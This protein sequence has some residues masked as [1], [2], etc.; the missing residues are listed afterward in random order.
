MGDMAD[1][2]IDGVTPMARRAAG[3]WPTPENVVASLA[4][5]FATAADQEQDTERR[6]IL[7]SI[8]SFLAGTGKDLAAEV[9]AKVVA[10]Q[11]GLG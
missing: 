7:R 10:R 4:V 8:A 11:T 6:G 3:Q 5:V 1:W 2:S 9:V